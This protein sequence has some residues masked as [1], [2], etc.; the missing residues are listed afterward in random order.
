LSEIRLTPAAQR[1]L[2]D[3]F[4]HSVHHWGL[5]QAMR[6]VH[7]LDL[8]LA[9][10]VEAPARGQKCA[11]IRA[12]YRRFQVDKHFVYFQIAD[13]GIAV[14]RILHYRMNAASQLNA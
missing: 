10:L 2:E 1:D 7:A 12:G 13:Y 3:I 14:V 6:Y 4:D 5:T 9:A 11:H 8:A